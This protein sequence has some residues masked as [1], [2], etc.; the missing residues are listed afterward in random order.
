MQRR[1]FKFVPLSGLCL[2]G[3][4]AAIATAKELDLSTEPEMRKGMTVAA[5]YAC[6]A[7]LKDRPKLTDPGKCCDQNCVRCHQDMEQHHPIGAEIIEKNKISLP[8]LSGL[9]VGCISC[10]DAFSARTDKR[11]WKSQ[12]LF[13]KWFQGQPTYKTYY[14]RINNSDGKLCKTCH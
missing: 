10:H 6:H 12:S 9:R 3:L 7:T 13:A 2:F 5:C 4:V 14:L 1:I 8:L 11:S